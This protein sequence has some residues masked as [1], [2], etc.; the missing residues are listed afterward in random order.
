MSK[1]NI[2]NFAHKIVV[3]DYGLHAV[4]RNLKDVADGKVLVGQI[5]QVLGPNFR[6]II[7]V[8]LLSVEWTSQFIIENDN[9]G[10][11]TH[12]EET[13]LGMTVTQDTEVSDSVSASAGFSG[14][15]TGS[16]SQ[17]M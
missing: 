8:E 15:G 4:Q 16:P 9:K 17:S 13:E 6:L 2:Q 14:W 1:S 5:C 3:G 12:E 10:E 11:R 7:D